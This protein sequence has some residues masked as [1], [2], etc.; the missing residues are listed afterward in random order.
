LAR[1]REGRLNADDV[2]GQKQIEK[3]GKLG[4]IGVRVLMLKWGLVGWAVFEERNG[5]G[6]DWSL[7]RF[8]WENRAGMC[9]CVCRK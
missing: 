9:V 7:M 4:G 1:E 5:R 6:E 3:G 2:D 8:W